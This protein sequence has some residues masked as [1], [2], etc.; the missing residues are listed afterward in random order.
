MSDQKEPD[1]TGQE[2]SPK[3]RRAGGGMI[4]PALIILVIAAWCV[5][6]GF[7]TPDPTGEYVLFNKVSAVVLGLGGIG[8]LAYELLRPTGTPGSNESDNRGPQNGS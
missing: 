6:D 3:T 1:K 8:L 4:F 2:P 5:K 7:I